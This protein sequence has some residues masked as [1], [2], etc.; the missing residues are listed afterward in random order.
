[1]RKYLAI[2]L[3]ILMLL[4]QGINLTFANATTPSFSQSSTGIYFDGSSTSYLEIASN[5]NFELG[6]NDFT[7]AWWQKAPKNQTLYP[8]LFQFGTGSA[9]SDGFAVSEEGGKLYF[10]RNTTPPPSGVQGE[11]IAVELP[12]TP[13]TWNHFAIVK[14]GTDFKIYLNGESQNLIS[15]TLNTSNCAPTS[16][17]SY[18]LLIGGSNE[19][20]LGGFQGEV[21]GFQM[22]KGAKW[23][24]NFTAPTE[25]SSDSCQQRD[26]NNNCTLEALILLYPTSDFSSTSLNNLI[27]SQSVSFPSSVTYGNPSATPT[28][29][30]SISDSPTPTPS[31]SVYNYQVTLERPDPE[32]DQ[33]YLCLLDE[34]NSVNSQTITI[35]NFEEYFIDINSYTGYEIESIIITPENSSSV[36][37]YSTIDEI[38]VEDQYGSEFIFEW[39]EFGLLIPFNFSNFIIK[40]NFQNIQYK[41]VVLNPTQNGNVCIE[42]LIDECWFSD[43]IDIKYVS[44]LKNS[45]GNIYFNPFNGYRFKDLSIVLDSTEEIVTYSSNVGEFTVTESG[46]DY[47]FYWLDSDALSVPEDLSSFNISV[48]FESIPI[49]FASISNGPSFFENEDPI[50]ISSMNPSEANDYSGIQS[51]LIEISYFPFDPF[52]PESES[53][54]SFCRH[55]LAEDSWEKRD[56]DQKLLIWL[57][58][59]RNSFI[60]DCPGYHQQ[61][62]MT[63]A[64]VYFFS[65]PVISE[66]EIDDDF[67]RTRMQRVPIEIYS[68]P[69]FENISSDNEVIEGEMID[70][71]VSNIDA[72]SSI[73]F[74]FYSVEDFSYEFCQFGFDLFDSNGDLKDI[75][76]DQV[77]TGHFNIEIPSYEEINSSCLGNNNYDFNF[78]REGKIEIDRDQD[79]YFEI[80]INDSFSQGE[81]SPLFTLK[82]SAIHIDNTDPIVKASSNENT[83]PTPSPSVISICNPVSVVNV[84]FEG[85]SSKIQGKAIKQIA[86]INKLIKLCGYKNLKLTGYTSIDKPDS[87]G[88]RI[89][90]KNLSLARANAVKTAISKLNNLKIKNLKYYVLG[91]SELNAIKS[92]RSKKTRPANRRVEVILK[93]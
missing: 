13:N 24:T 38:I 76:I 49:Q 44:V 45:R 7:I 35:S 15:N 70:F 5:S 55:F 64:N 52:N 80:L 9:N 63:S 86:Q 2:F 43:D 3:P 34:C 30:P 82:S 54:R 75:Y 29:T 37:S 10:W 16:T 19:A 65:T 68:P 81:G 6:C 42:D 91:K 18:P 39:G 90:R 31:P 87:P 93:Y 14:N 71:D 77:A 56:N 21:T 78:F 40:V 53:T 66:D 73:N 57:P 26:V 79:Y 72:V 27:D 11:H 62:P 1:M 23:V 8:R 89:F 92:N 32:Y 88:Y 58:E 67:L 41:T 84:N 48:T 69:G 46:K 4:T 51:L 12:D 85:G 83:S 33:G 61:S 47:T 50:E 59:L 20:G 74:F 22:F 17:G 25:F 28:P 36:T 60:N